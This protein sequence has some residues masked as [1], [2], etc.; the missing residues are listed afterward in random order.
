MKA[1]DVS[2]KETRSGGLDIYVNDV[3]TDTLVIVHCYARHYEGSDPFIVNVTLRGNYAMQPEE[4]SAARLYRE[5]PVVGEAEYWARTA[6]A[7]KLR[8]A[9]RLPEIENFQQIESD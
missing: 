3:E 7:K 6:R 1:S 2:V 4:P 8:R 5:A 9:V